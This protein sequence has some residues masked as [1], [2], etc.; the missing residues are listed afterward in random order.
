M[1]N[2]KILFYGIEEFQ[3]E[4]FIQIGSNHLSNII[5]DIKEVYGNNKIINLDID[6]AIKFSKELRKEISIAKD[7]KIFNSEN[8][9]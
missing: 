8:N 1:A 3:N 7:K 9:G 5:L 4:R 2:T 6:T